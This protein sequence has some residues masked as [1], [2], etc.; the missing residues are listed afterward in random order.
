MP[1]APAVVSAA[2]D[3]NA[4][5]TNGSPGIDV[6]KLS[7]ND[8]INN[9]T[10]DGGKYIPWTTS[11]TAPG[12]GSGFIKDGQFCIE[13]TNKGPTP[14]TRRRAT[15]RWSSSEGAHLFAVQ[16]MAHATQPTK[17]KAK[18]GM[19]GPPYKEY[20]TDTVDLT[21]HPQTFVGTFTME[22]ADDDATAELAFHFGGAMAGETPAPYNVCLDDIHL[23]DPKFAKAKKVEEAPIPNVLVNQT[24]YLPRA[25]QARHRQERVEDAAARGSCTSTAAAWWPRARPSRSAGTPP[26]ATTSTSPTSRRSRRRARATR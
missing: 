5:P 23:D 25:A 13:V 3:W 14:G 8:L 6:P 18:V 9:A 1:P 4:P 24:G 12:N 26:R 15:A 22:E 16:F 21:T 10:F 20:W 2:V 11:F 17:M 7:G 19:S